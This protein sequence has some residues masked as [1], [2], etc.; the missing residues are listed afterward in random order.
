MEAIKTGGTEKF[1]KI[2]P[3]YKNQSDTITNILKRVKLKDDEAQKEK[4]ELGRDIYSML[5]KIFR[6]HLVR[7]GQINF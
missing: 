3:E 2:F 6:G 1:F 7:F 5:K 4:Q